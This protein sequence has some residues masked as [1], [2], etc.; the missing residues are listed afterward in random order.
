VSFSAT[1]DVR[2]QARAFVKSVISPTIAAAFETHPELDV[3]DVLTLCEAY[4]VEAS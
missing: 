2:A 4:L 3:V 1:R